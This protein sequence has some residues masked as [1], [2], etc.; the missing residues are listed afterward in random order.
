MIALIS[1]RQEPQLVPACSAAPIA[2]TAGAAG[3]DGRGELV[4]A[5]IEAGA[6]DAPDRRHRHRRR[7]RTAAPCG[8][9]VDSGSARGEQRQQPVARGQLSG[10][11]DQQGFGHARPSSSTAAARIGRGRAGRCIRAAGRAETTSSKLARQQDALVRRLGA[12]ELVD[13]AAVDGC[14]GS[15]GRSR[16]A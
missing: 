16:S 10:R 8:R 2:S 3:G 4:D 11:R 1:E 13:P 9:V 7:G 15:N 12:A 5:D 6:D 14:A